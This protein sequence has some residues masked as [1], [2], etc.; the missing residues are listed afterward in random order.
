MRYTNINSRSPPAPS[1]VTPVGQ[2]AGWT[3]LHAAR[4]QTCYRACVCAKGLCPFLQTAQYEALPFPRRGIQPFLTNRIYHRWIS[5]TIIDPGVPGALGACGTRAHQHRAKCE[6]G[7]TWT[8]R[9]LRLALKNQHRP[10]SLITTSFFFESG[11]SRRPVSHSAVLH[12][13]WY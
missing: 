6:T 1:D 3:W 9:A 11:G 8:P 7:P 12:Q 13:G 2:C 10:S 4:H 5:A